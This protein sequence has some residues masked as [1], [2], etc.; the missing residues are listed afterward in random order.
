MDKDI[1][2]PGVRSSFSPKNLLTHILTRICTVSAE[3]SK[4][5]VKSAQPATPSS[6]FR[7]A[8]LLGQWPP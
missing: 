1:R 6:E 5:T 7:T 2:S 3:A 8:S 4:S